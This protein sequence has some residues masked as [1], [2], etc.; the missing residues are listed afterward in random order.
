M[1][2]LFFFAVSPGATARG[3]SG[4]PALLLGELH[5]DWR[6]LDGHRVHRDRPQPQAA[7]GRQEDGSAQTAAT[8]A[9]LQRGETQFSSKVQAS[10]LR[11]GCG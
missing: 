8:R 5:Q 3:Q 9:A 6:G 1:T 11:F 10:P 2:C 4:R 7:G